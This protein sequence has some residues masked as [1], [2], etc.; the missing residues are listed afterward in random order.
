MKHLSLRQSK[1]R[2]K[3]GLNLRPLFTAAGVALFAFSIL[4]LF[5]WGMAHAVICAAAGFGLLIFGQTA[6]RPPGRHRRY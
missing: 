2:T 6:P 3:R 1:I 5:E 4:A